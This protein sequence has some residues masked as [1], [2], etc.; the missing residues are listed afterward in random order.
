MM[1][2]RQRRAAIGIGWSIG[3]AAIFAVPVAFFGLSTQAIVFK[4]T[5]DK[6]FK[7]DVD[8]DKF[9]QI[10]VRANA[11]SAII[12]H[13]GMKLINERVNA[14]K[15]DLSKD[16]RPLLNALAGKSKA[17][18]RASKRLTVE[19]DDPQINAT[20]LLLNQDSHVTSS[21]IHVCTKS[22]ESAG[23]LQS[24][25]TTFDAAKSDLQTEVT[26]AVDMSIE[27]RV[28]PLFVSQAETRVQQ[29]AT[30]AVLDQ[31]SAIRKLVSAFDD[32]SLIVP[33]L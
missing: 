26:L 8:F 14:L 9:R 28:S 6:T 13:G 19:L 4:G 27:V 10:L 15:I 16:P 5:S 22:S 33:R 1:N 18:V 30:Q 32:K 29:A 24:Y 21:F 31:E 23:E 11:T 3:L 12:E 20:K 2:I 17:D 7:L 25:E